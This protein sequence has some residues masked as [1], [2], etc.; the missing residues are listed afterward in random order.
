MKPKISLITFAVHD[1]D[2]MLA[3]YRDGLGFPLHNYAP[4]D[5]VMTPR[6]TSGRSPSIRSRT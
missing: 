2:R 3:F 1:L 5:M 4:G 6:A